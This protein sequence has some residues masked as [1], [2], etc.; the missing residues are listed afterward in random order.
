MVTRAASDERMD[1]SSAATPQTGPSTP[2]VTTVPTGTPSNKL[3]AVGLRSA[4]SSSTLAS[5]VS[6]SRTRVKST[7]SMATLH[8]PETQFSS[9][10]YGD[11]DELGTA[12]ILD[13]QTGSQLKR[14][15]GLWFDDGSVICRVESNLFCVHMSVLERHSMFFQ[16]MFAIPQ[17]ATGQ[18][19]SLVIEGSVMR[20]GAQRIPVITLFDK[21]EDVSNLLNALYNIG[22]Y[23]MVLPYL[24]VDILMLGSSLPS[25]SC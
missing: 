17:P 13:V 11:K 6:Q 24:Y 21:A 12:T 14:H 23:V 4:G 5:L 25:S 19:D 1:S 3:A 7:R 8:A 10:K 18:S 20:H 22:P 16:D 2:T 15:K 9:L